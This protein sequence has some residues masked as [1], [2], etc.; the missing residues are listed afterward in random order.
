M[1]AP[2]AII[3]VACSYSVSGQRAFENLNFKPATPYFAAGNNPNAPGFPAPICAVLAD[4]DGDGRPDI[5]V[6]NYNLTNVIIFQNVSQ[7]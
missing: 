7:Y 4:I 1:K 5:A 2:I 6:G 3:L